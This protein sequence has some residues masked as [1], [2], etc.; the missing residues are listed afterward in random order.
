MGQVWD[1]GS[2]SCVAAAASSNTA[3]SADKANTLILQINRFLD[4]TTPAA[5]QLT[6]FNVGA[7]GFPTN[8]TIDQGVAMA[9]MALMQRRATDAYSN[10]KSTVDKAGAAALISQVNQGWSDPV[11]FVNGSIDSITA[12]IATYADLHGVA[13]AASSTIAG[14]DTTTILIGAA[15]VAALWIYG[16]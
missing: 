4:P 9:A 10:A 12:T 16:R 13:K 15:V 7:N 3:P 6:G 14:I 11:S 2:N 5:Y 1:W 8:G